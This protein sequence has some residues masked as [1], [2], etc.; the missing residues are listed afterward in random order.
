M[1]LP[2]ICL[3]LNCL[4]VHKMLMW[5]DRLTG[6]P[7]LLREAASCRDM[8]ILGDMVTCLKEHLTNEQVCQL[9][10]SVLNTI[11]HI[12]AIGHIVVSSQVGHQTWHRNS[13]TT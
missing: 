8:K 3:L 6:L 2:H 7:W 9:T 12:H 11:V 13:W 1:F 5:S 10:A 4:K